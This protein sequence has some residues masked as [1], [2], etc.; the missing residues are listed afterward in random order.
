LEDEMIMLKEFDRGDWGGMYRIARAYE[1]FAES[2][3][4]EQFNLVVARQEGWLVADGDELA[5]YVSL[6]DFR[7]LHSVILHATIRPEYHSRWITKS[8][9]G[10]VFGHL[11][12]PDRLDLVKVYSYAVYGVTYAAAKALDQMGFKRIG[13]DR[14]GLMVGGQCYDTIRYE[15]LREECPYV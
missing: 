1:P 5:G 10:T 14:K 4:P 15:M 3:T 8:V 7:P 9:L 6:S 12:H 11:F 2:V 13:V